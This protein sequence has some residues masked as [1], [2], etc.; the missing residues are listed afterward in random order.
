MTIDLTRR[1]FLRGL[2]GT[3]VI[4]ALPPIPATPV[5]D[6][7][8]ASAVAP[9]ADLTPPPGITYNWVRTSLLGEPD[10]ENMEDRIA[11]GWTFVLPS[12]H[13]EMP[14]AD[15]TIAFERRGLILMQCPTVECELRHAWEQFTRRDRLP[16]RMHKVMFKT[17]YVVQ[18]DGSI[19]DA[20]GKPYS[21]SVLPDHAV[22][23]DKWRRREIKA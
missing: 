20:D 3:V 21:G 15:A 10:I 17:G 22:I 6:P 4:A 1:S 7:L 8:L 5:T 13:P 12:A 2:A 16:E 18:N 19:I 23:A 14:V 11:N 9:A